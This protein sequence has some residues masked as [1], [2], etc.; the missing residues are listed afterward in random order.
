MK[1]IFFLFISS[2][3]VGAIL[4]AIFYWGLNWEL[5]TAVN[6]GLSGALGGLAAEFIRL[7]A[8]KRKRGNSLRR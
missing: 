6:V 2:L 8:E 3:V 1:R 4:F 7:Y 5:V